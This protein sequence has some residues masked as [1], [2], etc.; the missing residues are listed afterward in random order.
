MKTLAIDGNKVCLGC[1]EEKSI[2]EFGVDSRGYVLARCRPCRNLQRRR[3]RKKN[4]ERHR[5]ADRAYYE[6]NKD[7]ARAYRL[8]KEYGVT[9]EQFEAMVDEQDGRCFLC[10][11]EPTGRHNGSVLHMDHDHETKTPRR[12]LCQNCNNGLGHFLDDPELL[13]KAAAYI[14]EFR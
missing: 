2:S 11:R 8:Q 1:S 6:R 10:E 14:E 4:P 9:I 7:K 3:Y 12:P 13:R 5:E